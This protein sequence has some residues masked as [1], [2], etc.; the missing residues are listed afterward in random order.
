M[1]TLRGEQVLRLDLLMILPERETL[2]LGERFLQ[3]GRELVVAHCADPGRF[4]PSA[5]GGVRPRF[6]RRRAAEVDACSAH[7]HH[8]MPRVLHH[9]LG[10][11]TEQ[12]ARELRAPAV[13]DD[14]QVHRMPV[15]VVDDLLGRMSHGHLEMRLDAR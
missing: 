2:R 11:R 8:R 12:E 3:L 7:D 9:L 4:I 13:S 14:D 1:P 10:D 5:D 6:K 15:G